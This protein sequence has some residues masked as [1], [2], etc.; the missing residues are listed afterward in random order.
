[1]AEQR[2]TALVTGAASGIGRA[3]VGALARHGFDVAINYNSNEAGAREMLF[4]PVQLP[5]ARNGQHVCLSND[6]FMAGFQAA[7]SRLSH[8]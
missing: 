3:A 7:M 1:M 8:L 6:G 4:V 5:P 2:R